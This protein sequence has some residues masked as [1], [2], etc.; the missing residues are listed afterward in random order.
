MNSDDQGD[1][2]VG[3]CFIYTSLAIIL[4]T[5]IVSSLIG[6]SLES[7]GVLLFLIDIFGPIISLLFFFCLIIAPLIG[8]ILIVRQTKDL[9]IGFRSIKYF[10]L[11]I[12][13]G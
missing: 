10:F 9:S 7:Q 12:F 3:V 2:F 1:V 4:F 11:T 6:R 5:I 13:H 8:S